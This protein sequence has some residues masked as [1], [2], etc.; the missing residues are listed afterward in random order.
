LRIS[1]CIVGIQVTP[2]ISIY[3]HTTEAV[4]LKL[5]LR[6]RNTKNRNRLSV[7][8]RRGG[9]SEDQ[10]KSL[11]LAHSNYE[12]TSRRPSMYVRVRIGAS[13]FDVNKH[14]V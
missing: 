3:G 5:A 4:L 12:A 11:D 1:C 2:F 10:G 9:F 8:E 7:I 14:V 6:V 13:G